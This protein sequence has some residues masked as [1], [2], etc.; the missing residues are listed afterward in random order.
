MRR[1][2]MALVILGGSATSALAAVPRL[3]NNDADYVLMP[4]LG[5]VAIIVGARGGQLFKR[6][7]LRK[8]E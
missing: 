6:R 5:Y 7:L 8:V 4:L 2:V 1:L 3:T